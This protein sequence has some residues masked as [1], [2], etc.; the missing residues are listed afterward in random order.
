MAK[1]ITKS[2]RLTA[3]AWAALDELRASA[4]RTQSGEI[5]WLILL[6]VTG[7]REAKEAHLNSQAQPREG[8][9]YERN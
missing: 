3:E 9:D 6:A 4:V 2:I 1:T 8:R 7:R 5:E